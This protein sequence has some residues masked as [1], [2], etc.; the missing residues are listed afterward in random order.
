MEDDDDNY[1]DEKEENVSLL[2]I[3]LIQSIS[4]PWCRYMSLR[5]ARLLKNAMLPFNYYEIAR[6]QITVIVVVAVVPVLLPL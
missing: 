5:R 6:Y 1:D 4:Q 3:L 2:Y